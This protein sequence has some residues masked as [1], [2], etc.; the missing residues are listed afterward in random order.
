M[1]RL[2]SLLVPI[3]LAG[4]LH[5]AAVEQKAVQATIRAAPDRAPA[6]NFGLSDGSG[7][8][9]HLSDYRGRPVVVNLWATDC[10]GCKIELPSF[11]KLSQTYRDGGVS[12]LGVSMDIMYE[13]LKNAAEGWAR[14]KPFAASH[15]L[16][17]PILLDDGSVE[18]AYAVTALPATY[19][20]D[21]AGRI[22]ASYVGIV[23][24]ADLD[25]NVKTLLAER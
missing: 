23:D 11:V 10:G 15:G 7:K 2:R 14:V 22:A 6:P 13:G 3:L 16:T 21:R 24:A 4:A 25:A 20:I 19:L 12:V 17:Y 8:T 5:T 18:K 9:R 1:K